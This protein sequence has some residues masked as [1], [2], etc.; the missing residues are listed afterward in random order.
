MNYVI[1]QY[2]QRNLRRPNCRPFPTPRQSYASVSLETSQRHRTHH[3][4]SQIR[5]S[6]RSQP[7][8]RCVRRYH[9][10]PSLRCRLQLQEAPSSILC[11]FTHISSKPFPNLS[12]CSF[13]YV[14]TVLCVKSVFQYRLNR[15]E[16]GGDNRVPK[17][18]EWPPSRATIGVCGWR[19]I[20]VG[21]CCLPLGAAVSKRVPR[22]G[23]HGLATSHGVMSMRSKR[24]LPW[25]S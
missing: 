10:R 17:H 13:L 6:P 8:E 24:I 22:S 11:S 18:K 9:Q 3:R 25:A 15:R 12:F 23:P 14:P 1:V 16:L 21:C 7:S 19:E 2:S 20:D 5:T 4:P